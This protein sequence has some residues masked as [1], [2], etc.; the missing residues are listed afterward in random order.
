M[1]YDGFEYK[2]EPTNVNAVDFRILLG[3]KIKKPN[4]RVYID[5]CCYEYIIFELLKQLQQNDNSKIDKIKEYCLDQDL[6]NDLTALDILIIIDGKDDTF[7]ER[8]IK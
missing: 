1:D 4:A 8:K 6:K 2:E 5:P 3:K 7:Y